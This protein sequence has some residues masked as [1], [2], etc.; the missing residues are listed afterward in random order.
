MDKGVV[1]KELA[2]KLKKDHP[3]WIVDNKDW[4]I[5]VGYPA[6][7]LSNQSMNPDAVIVGNLIGDNE[8]EQCKF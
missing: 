4:N 1:A 8:S 7:E 3:Y 5:K 2:L 6:S